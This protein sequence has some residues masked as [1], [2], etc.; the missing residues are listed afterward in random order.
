MLN[1]NPRQWRCFILTWK[2]N[3]NICNDR[4]KEK[5]NSPEFNSQYCGV[6]WNCHT[7][8]HGNTLTDVWK[9]NILFNKYGGKRW[10]CIHFVPLKVTNRSITEVPS[11]C[12]IFSQQSPFLRWG[13]SLAGVLDSVSLSM[14]LKNVL[15][16]KI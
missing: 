14:T 3:S 1:R 13:D 9:K 10:I 4:A 15:I 8:L 12:F 5:K 11:T 7:F 2:S 16:P 6:Q